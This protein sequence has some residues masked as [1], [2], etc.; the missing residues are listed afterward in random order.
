[1]VGF[2][3]LLELPKPQELFLTV[4]YFPKPAMCFCKISCFENVWNKIHFLCFRLPIVSFIL[5]YFCLPE[6]PAWLTSKGRHEEA[7]AIMVRIHGSTTASK[8]KTTQTPPENNKSVIRSLFSASTLRPF[9]IMNLFFFFQQFSGTFVV[10]FYAVD[11]VQEAGI[12]F[13][14][15][16]AAII[17]G[18]TRFLVTV[19]VSFVSNR[20]GRR[21]PAIVSGAGMTL[22]MGCLAT[23]LYISSTNS[24]LPTTAERLAWLPVV[25]LILYILTSTIGF[26]TIPWAMVGEVFPTKVRG[27]AAGLTTFCAYFYSFIIIKIY[28]DM[29]QSL[30]R[31]GLFFFYGGISVLGTIFV[32]FFLPETKGRDLQEIEEQFKRKKKR[33][34]RDVEE[35]KP[36]HE[37]S[38]GVSIVPSNH[39]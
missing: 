19:V 37:I 7:A 10:V 21:P 34:I 8:P 30:S 35:E 22:C 27:V 28:P 13:D 9:L 14:P 6:S 15:F 36:L 39:K 23:F 3:P 29:L 11:I 2:E 31:Y 4:R 18:L 16:L 33:I 1:M 12:T 17:I 20:Y 38:N 26:L 25:S 5:T 24:I 32:V